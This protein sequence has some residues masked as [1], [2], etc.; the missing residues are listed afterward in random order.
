MTNAER[1]FRKT[2][3][4]CKRFIEH[5]GYEESIGL[6]RVAIEDDENIT[7]KT[8][9][10]MVRLLRSARHTVENSKELGVMDETKF[11]SETQLLNMIE[12]TIMNAR[13][14]IA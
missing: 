10:E 12:S 14:N 4:E 2:R 8:L 6:N 9:D 7:E 5:Y 3:I 11:A 13:K 1:I